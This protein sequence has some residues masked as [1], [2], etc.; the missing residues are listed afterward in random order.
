[1]KL[2][3]FEKFIIKMIKDMWRVILIMVLLS[4][5]ALWSLLEVLTKYVIP[6]LEQLHN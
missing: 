1:M 5:V 6:H 4:A 3:D 2:N